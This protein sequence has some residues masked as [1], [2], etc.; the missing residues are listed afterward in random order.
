MQVPTNAFV[1]ICNPIIPSS[2][3]VPFFGVCFARVYLIDLT[4]FAHM[5]NIQAEVA[6]S[7]VIGTGRGSLK[8]HFI[9]NSDTITH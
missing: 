6:F 9:H 3:I 8:V 4:V 5:N 7:R 2:R 1:F